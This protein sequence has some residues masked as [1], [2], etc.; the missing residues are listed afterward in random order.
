MPTTTEV[1]EANGI[2]VPVIAWRASQTVGVPYWA[3]CAFLEQETAGGQNVYG[4]D[5]G[6]YSG[7]GEVTEANY[8]DYKAGRDS[9]NAQGVGPMQLTWPPYQDQADA[10]GGCWDPAV[11]ITTGLTILAGFIHSGDTWHEAAAK[12]NGSDG[13]ADQIDAKITRWQALLKDAQP[14]GGTMF[15]GLY[16][17][18][19]YH[20][21]GQPAH[22][23]D[24]SPVLITLRLQQALARLKEALGYTEDMTLEQGCYHDGSKSAGTHAGA[25]AIDLSENDY[26]HKI[27]QGTKIG[28]IMWHRPY[29]WDGAGGGAHIHCLLRGSRHFSPEAAAQVPD[30]DKH[31]D[32]LAYHHHYDGP[33]Y[34]VH[35]FVW[36]KQQ[37]VQQ[38]PWPAVAAEAHALFLR[39]QAALKLPLEWPIIKAYRAALL[40]QWRILHRVSYPPK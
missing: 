14:P 3:A 17:P 32:G 21:Q 13:Y 25:D 38:V 2:V 8:A 29:N 37:H 30:W 6:W 40:D 15:T 1:A 5:G 33:W 36:Q 4:H 23:D 27:E 18:V 16:A 19:Q 22:Y 26:A 12:Y 20:F 9:H 11:N 7:A 28:L 31:L 39:Y 10:D 35:N 24:G 34:P